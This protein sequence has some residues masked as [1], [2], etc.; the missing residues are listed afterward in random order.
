MARVGFGRAV[1]DLKYDTFTVWI[2]DAI[3]L[4]LYW[5]QGGGVAPSPLTTPLDAIDPLG[6]SVAIEIPPGE[7]Y[8][9]KF[10]NRQN[11]ATPTNFLTSVTVPINGDYSGRM[12]RIGCLCLFTLL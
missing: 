12:K 6:N 10:F 2:S 7:V 9:R 4:T 1:L 8:G 5:A 3:S 11:L